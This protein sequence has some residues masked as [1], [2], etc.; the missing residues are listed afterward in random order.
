M[1]GLRTYCDGTLFVD[2]AS[3]FSGTVIFSKK[4]FCDGGSHRADTYYKGEQIFTAGVKH[5]D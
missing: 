2:D 1:R 5:S 4:N 3:V